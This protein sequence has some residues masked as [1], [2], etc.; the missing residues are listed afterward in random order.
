ML[1]SCLLG[2]GSQ[3]SLRPAEI[4]QP[5]GQDFKFGGNPSIVAMC[6]RAPS[7]GPGHPSW[8]LSVVSH[9]PP[10]AKFPPR[11][12]PP[13]GPPSPAPLL[14]TQLQITE[15]RGLYLPGPHPQSTWRYSCP[16]KPLL[17]PSAFRESPALA[18]A[19]PASPGTTGPHPQA[20]PKCPGLSSQVST[21][22]CLHAAS[23]SALIPSPPSS[24]SQAY[25][26]KCHFSKPPY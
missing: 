23:C 15:G 19:S 14:P 25:T 2:E 21:A 22:V 12:L 18:L 5:G 8:V 3:T 20:S 10:T 7:L 16:Q 1:T 6:P 4:F 13:S 24:C 9:R 11:P 26:P 17:S